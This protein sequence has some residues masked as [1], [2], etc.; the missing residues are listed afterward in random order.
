[1]T[2]RVTEILD[3]FERLSADE[4]RRLASEILKRSASL[5]YQPLSDDELTEAADA[6]FQALDAAESA[7]GQP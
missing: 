2:Q 7:D 5:D 4:K 3:S 1:M 6:L